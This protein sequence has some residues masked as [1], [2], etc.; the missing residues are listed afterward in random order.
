ML[1]CS[2]FRGCL[3]S[4]LAACLVLTVCTGTPRILAAALVTQEEINSVR[5]Y[6]KM[7]NATVLIASAYVSA[8]HTR[9][10]IGKRNRVGCADR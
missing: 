5:V 2:L 9:A 10:G 8:H 4:W 1:R 6:K 7:A 3:R